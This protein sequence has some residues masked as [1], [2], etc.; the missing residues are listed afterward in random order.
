MYERYYIMDILDPNF[1][2]ILKFNRGSNKHC[3]LYPSGSEP[4]LDHFCGNRMIILFQKRDCIL[5]I[6][7]GS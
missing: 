6:Q 2:G 3:N 4:K 1:K 5:Y 7:V